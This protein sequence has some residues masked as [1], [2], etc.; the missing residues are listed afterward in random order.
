LV[1]L[2]GFLFGWLVWFGLVW[3]GLVWFGLV[4]SSL[5]FVS[6]TFYFLSTT[7]QMFGVQSIV[8]NTAASQTSDVIKLPMSGQISSSL[9]LFFLY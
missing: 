4:W 1:L 6:E 5:V 7:L 2:W 3:F 9:C 8:D